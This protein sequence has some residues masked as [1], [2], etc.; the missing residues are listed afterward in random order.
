MLLL[1][2]KC[3]PGKSFRSSLFRL[4]VCLSGRDFLLLLQKEAKQGKG[5]PGF[6]LCNPLWRLAV[7]DTNDV[8]IVRT[9]HRCAPKVAT[10]VSA[11]SP[12]P[13]PPL[14]GEGMSIPIP[15]YP[16]FHLGN[17]F[18]LFPW[19]IFPLWPHRRW[20]FHAG[21]QYPFPS[22]NKRVR[23]PMAFRT[24]SSL[25]LPAD[26]TP[27]NQSPPAS[28]GHLPLPAHQRHRR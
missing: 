21:T 2:H 13:P 25:S 3:A 22:K 9:A 23:Q 11:P 6:P 24:F 26:I 27:R 18:L 4:S 12:L 20:S 5:E 10:G 1:Y 19:K 28:P 17:C 7:L 16:L 8:N 14:S 15:A